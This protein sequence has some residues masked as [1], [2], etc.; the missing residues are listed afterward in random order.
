M[1]VEKSENERHQELKKDHNDIQLSIL[2]N[3]HATRWRYG[4]TYTTLIKEVQNLQEICCR[5][6]LPSLAM[7]R[8]INFFIVIFGENVFTL[9]P[10]N[11]LVLCNILQ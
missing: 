10:S 7:T 6:S 2:L 3:I 4:E 9:A 11:G 1:K 8:Y 5:E